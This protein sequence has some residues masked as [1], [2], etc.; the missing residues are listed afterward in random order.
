MQ[1]WTQ[2][3]QSYQCCTRPFVYNANLTV[4]KNIF[5]QEVHWWFSSSSSAHAGQTKT[6]C[7]EWCPKRLQSSHITKPSSTYKVIDSSTDQ[8]IQT[9][10]GTSN[11]AMKFCKKLHND[12]LFGFITRFVFLKELCMVE[13]QFAKGLWRRHVYKTLQVLMVLKRSG[14]MLD[15]MML[16]NCCWG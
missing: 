3:F 13:I 1:I 12:S 11:F 15:C 7:V 6:Q 9:N 8:Q 10:Y 14:A 16:K 2:I 4:K 5:L